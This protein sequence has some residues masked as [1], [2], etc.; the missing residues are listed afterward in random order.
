[1]AAGIPIGQPP[2]ALTPASTP[3]SF[4]LDVLAPARMLFTLHRGLFLWTPLTF[5]GAVGVVL[6]V[7]R[8]RSAEVRAVSFFAL[9]SLG[10]LLFYVVLGGAWD[11]GFSFSQRFLSGWFPLVVVGVAYLVQQR[12]RFAVPMVV[13]CTAFSVFVGMNVLIGYRGQSSNDGVQHIVGLYFDGERSIPQLIRLTAVRAR[14][15]WRQ[16]AP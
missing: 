9:A 4:A 14:E 1:V 16:L 6:L 7:L 12:R 5:I 11:A 3:N 10:T 8:E 2:A 15:R 13:L